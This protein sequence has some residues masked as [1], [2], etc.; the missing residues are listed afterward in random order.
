MWSFNFVLLPSEKQTRKTTVVC[1]TD[2]TDWFFASTFPPVHL[3]SVIVLELATE[4]K[5]LSEARTSPP[6]SSG[7]SP[8]VLSLAVE[9]TESKEIT[10]G[11]SH[12]PGFIKIGFGPG[13]C[14]SLKRWR[15][16][17][18]QPSKLWIAGWKGRVWATKK[19]T[20][21]DFWAAWLSLDGT[22][23]WIRSL[24]PWWSDHSYVVT[25]TGFSTL[26]QRQAGETVV[27]GWK[28]ALLAQ[29]PLFSL[30]SV[31]WSFCD[32]S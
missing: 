29:E 26:S 4:C 11:I 16:A 2:F 22:L 30:S 9:L 28:R 23:T 25:R 32:W 12:F 15:K 27:S 18:R 6:P 1:L 20:L 10:K 7:V 24:F 31:S 19:I 13:L 8:A 14:G 17:W 21:S 5:S 3:L